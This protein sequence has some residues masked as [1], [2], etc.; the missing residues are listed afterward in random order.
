MINLRT[1]K[2]LINV[3]WVDHLIRILIGLALMGLAAEGLI[4]SW[5]WIGMVP[6]ITGAFR[7]CPVYSL[8]GINTCKDF[9]NAK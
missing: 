7:Y 1:Y 6:L 3:G 4:S 5:G 9:K 8:F 2:Q